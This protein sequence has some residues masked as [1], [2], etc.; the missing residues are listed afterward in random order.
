MTLD[1]REALASGASLGPWRYRP[2]NLTLE[3]ASGY[4]VDLERCCSSAEVLDCLC[5]VASK[6]WCSDEALGQLVRLLDLLLRPQAT[7]CSCGRGRT[8][9]GGRRG[10]RQLLA[11]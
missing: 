2:D 9:P 7:L 11:P 3:H 1:R 10:V 8:I 5:Q 6:A 4:Y